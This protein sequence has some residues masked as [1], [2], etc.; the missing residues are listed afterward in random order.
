[1]ISHDH[2]ARFFINYLTNQV[3]CLQLLRIIPSAVTNLDSP[4]V[5]VPPSM[6]TLKRKDLAVVGKRRANGG[7]SLVRK[8]WSG[9]FI[10]EI[11]AAIVTV[12]DDLSKDSMPSMS[13][14]MSHFLLCSLVIAFL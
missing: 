12:L 13:P 9:Q 11:F 7:K 6:R 3:V 2:Q 10:D 14:G 8:Q 1:M 4:T 5:S